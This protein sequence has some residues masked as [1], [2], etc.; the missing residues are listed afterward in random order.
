MTGPEC[1]QQVVT[2]IV[3]Q[4]NE[5]GMSAFVLTGYITTVNEEGEEVIER[6]VIANGGGNAPM[7]DGL[8]PMVIM[9]ARWKD[10]AL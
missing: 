9:G 8:R 7:Q 10:G 1:A 4:L 5:L 2:K 6:H 3:P